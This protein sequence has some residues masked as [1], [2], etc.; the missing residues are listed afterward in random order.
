MLCLSVVC[1]VCKEFKGASDDAICIL[2]L[3]VLAALCAELH[4]RKRK[5]KL[6]LSMTLLL[7]W[8][9]W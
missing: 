2:D 7:I 1:Y 8:S 6:L 9:T 4:L 5:F 3:V